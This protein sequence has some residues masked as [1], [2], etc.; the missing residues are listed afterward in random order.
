MDQ[1][2]DKL[3]RVFIP[4]AMQIQRIYGLAAYL[5]AVLPK[6]KPVCLPDEVALVFYESKEA[7]R[8]TME[9]PGGRAYQDMHAIVFSLARSQS[10]FPEAFAGSVQP[11]TAYHLLDTKAD[12]QTC[13]VELW[14][15][16][17]R[18]DMNLKSYLGSLSAFA[19]GLQESPKKISGAILCAEECRGQK[20]SPTGCSKRAQGRHLFLSFSSRVSV[21]TRDVATKYMSLFSSLFN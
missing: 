19:R 18:K 1:F 17:R 8:A 5:P 14:A 3:A 13:P 6:D 15:G 10:G 20:D 21:R 7:Y 12:W 11:G 4:I 2:F 9:Y 16:A